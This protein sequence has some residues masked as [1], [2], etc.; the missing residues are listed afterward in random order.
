MF[1][2]FFAQQTQSKQKDTHTDILAC[3]FVRGVACSNTIEPYTDIDGTIK[4]QAESAE[5][6]AMVQMARKCG[7]FKKSKQPVQLEVFGGRGAGVSVREW[8]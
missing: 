4:F 5:E 7:F 1:F 2:I 8:A 3:N 6:L